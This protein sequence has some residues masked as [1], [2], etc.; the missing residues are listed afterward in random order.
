MSLMIIISRSIKVSGHGRNVL[1]SIL[2]G[3]KFAEFDSSDFCKGITF[4][5]FFKRCCQKSLFNDRLPGVFGIDAATSEE[6][7]TLDIVL[8]SFANEMSGNQ[9]IFIKKISR[10]TLISNNST[11]FRCSNNKSV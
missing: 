6:K 10:V 7:K 9:K 1:S 5:C 2:P 3:V 8:M 4:I 11:H